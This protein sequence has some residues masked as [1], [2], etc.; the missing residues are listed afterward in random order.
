MDQK[1]NEVVDWI[2]GRGRLVVAAVLAVIV[3]AVV[4]QLVVGLF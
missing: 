4:V 2:T 3:V 1:P